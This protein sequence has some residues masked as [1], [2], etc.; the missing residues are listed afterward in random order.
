MVTDRS[1]LWGQSHGGRPVRESRTPVNM[2]NQ[3]HCD[4]GEGVATATPLPTRQRLPTGE[5]IF[6]VMMVQSLK[7]VDLTAEYAEV[8]EGG[9]IGQMPLPGSPAVSATGQSPDFPD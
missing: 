2:G 5:D 3:P 8:A 1:P 9:F 6:S 7:T 4:N